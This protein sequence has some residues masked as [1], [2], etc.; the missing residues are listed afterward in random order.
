MD[1]NSQ[2]SYGSGNNNYG[3]SDNGQMADGR[4]SKHD[5]SYSLAQGAFILSLCAVISSIFGTIFLPVCLACIAL[6]L[7]ILSRGADTHFLPVAKRAAI[8]SAIAIG[9]NAAY[10]GSSIA[11]LHNLADDPA[12]YDQLNMVVE[13]YTGSSIAEIAQ[14]IDDDLGTDLTGFMGIDESTESEDNTETAPEDPGQE[15]TIPENELNGQS[16]TWIVEEVPD[17]I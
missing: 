17:E 13:S 16:V 14:S 7:A 4:R 11:T 5:L 3:W 1:W 9:I 2:N 12:L 10:I 8:F 6:I 15:I